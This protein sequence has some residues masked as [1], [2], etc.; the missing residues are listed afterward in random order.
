MISRRSLISFLG[1]GS[2]GTFAAALSRRVSA[3][4]GVHDAHPTPD[5]VAEATKNPPPANAPRAG[6]FEPVRTLN[7]WTLPY[8]LKDGVKEFHLVAE[9]IEHEFAPGCRAKCWGYN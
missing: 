2:I 7:G 3:A 5:P 4:D 9:E 1:T 6:G 8:T